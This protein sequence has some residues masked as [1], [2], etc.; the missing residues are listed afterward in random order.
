MEN[1]VAETGETV[2]VAAEPGAFVQD[3]SY[4]EQSPEMV[5]VTALQAERRE[6]QQ[7]QEQNKLLQDHMS[8]MQ[9]N[10]PAQAAQKQDRDA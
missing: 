7:L 9:S 4:A 10:Q 1:A 8:L 6:R 3:Q 2:A 5:P